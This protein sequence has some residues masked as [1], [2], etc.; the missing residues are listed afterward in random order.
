MEYFSL[1]SPTALFLETITLALIALLCYLYYSDFFI[2]LRIKNNITRYLYKNH[3]RLLKNIDITIA[4]GR[5]LFIKQLLVS[6]YGLYILET[7]QYRGQIYGSHHQVKW[8]SKGRISSKPFK[9]PHLDQQ[10]LCRMLADYLKISPT[11]CNV[12]VVFTGQTRFT[13]EIPANTCKI[14]NLV[15]SIVQQRNILI[16][17]C[18]LPSIISMLDPVIDHRLVA[19]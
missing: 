5:R 9:N 4:D 15:T 10:N 8:L 7:C 12:M 1:T 13:S 17:P 6:R 11:V 18:Q 3:Y 16:N 19:D 14:Q 2:R